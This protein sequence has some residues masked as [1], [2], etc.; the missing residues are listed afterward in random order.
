MK[1]EMGLNNRKCWCRNEEKIVMMGIVG[2][3]G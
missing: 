1:Q 2:K 3:E